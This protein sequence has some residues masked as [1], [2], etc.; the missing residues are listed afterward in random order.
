MKKIAVTG[1]KGGTGK[2]TIATAVSIELSKHGSVLLVDADVNCPD[3]HLILGMERKEVR[4]VESMIPKFDEEKCVKC[5]KCAEVCEE[6][7]IVQVKDRCPI[8]VPEQ[9]TGCRACKIVCPVGAIS[10]D[11]QVIGEIFEGGDDVDLVAGEMRP[12]IEESSLVANDMKKYIKEIESDYDYVVIDTAAGTHCPVIAALMDVD[13]GLAVTEPTPL[14]EHDLELIIKLM[15]ELGVESKII[16]NRSDIADK[17]G[18]FKIS[19]RYGSE[20]VT[21]I[22]YRKEI[23][24]NY[25]EGVPVKSPEIRKLAEDLI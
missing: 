13:L 14:G 2:S 23:E 8:F 19:E 5:G 25:S 21:E 10:E 24:R 15:E 18:V 11:E 12:G 17:E 20:V 1:G 7:A 9:C 6:N 4:D 16:I 22:P 3:D